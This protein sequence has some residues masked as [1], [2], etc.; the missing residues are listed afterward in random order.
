MAIK[1][2][3][4]PK[5]AETNAEGRKLTSQKGRKATTQKAKAVAKGK[6]AIKKK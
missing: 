6:T 3:K 2:G 1:F 5:R 4:E